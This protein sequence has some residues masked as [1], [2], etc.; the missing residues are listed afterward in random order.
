[1]ACIDRCCIGRTARWCGGGDQTHRDRAE[2]RLDD[3]SI[4]ALTV[5]YGGVEERS[6]AVHTAACLP[7]VNGDARSGDCRPGHRS[8]GAVDNCRC[9]AD[10]AAL[11]LGATC[12][13]NRSATA[14]NEKRC[15]ESAHLEPCRIC[16]QLCG[17]LTK[18]VVLQRL[19]MD[20]AAG[21]GTSWICAPWSAARTA[22]VT[23]PSARRNHHRRTPLLSRIRP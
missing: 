13:G 12:T 15:H 6:Y 11:G 21:A 17:G 16:V 18:G 19:L 10:V 2:V 5:C 20:V 4:V 22:F 14:H 8:Y 9:S 23:A 7:R 1:M 3:S